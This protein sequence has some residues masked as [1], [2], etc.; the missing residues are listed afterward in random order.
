[1]DSHRRY[2]VTEATSNDLT[3]KFQGA[4][5]AGFGVT[6]VTGPMAGGLFTL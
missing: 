2:G 4:S 5:G 6:T 3:G 1:M